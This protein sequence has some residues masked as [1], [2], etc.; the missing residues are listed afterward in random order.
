MRSCDNNVAYCMLLHFYSMLVFL[1][2]CSC[3]L[4][5]KASSELSY[6]FGYHLLFRGGFCVCSVGL[7]SA[8]PDHPSAETSGRRSVHLS[9]LLKPRRSI[10]KHMCLSWGHMNGWTNRKFCLSGFLHVSKAQAIN[11]TVSK[12]RAPVHGRALHV[13]EHLPTETWREQFSETHYITAF[14]H[15]LCR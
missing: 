14:L 4:E 10:T 1:H 11:L 15:S 7:L 3:L 2:F 13:G 6:I 9:G 5:I 12:R 8:H